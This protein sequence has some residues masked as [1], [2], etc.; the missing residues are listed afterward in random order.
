MLCTLVIRIGTFPYALR[1]VAIPIL[2][3]KILRLLDVNL[4]GDN[5]G[6]K[7]LVYTAFSYWV[8]GGAT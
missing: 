3:T 6:L 1:A 7:L 8:T 5:K 2:Q 4:R